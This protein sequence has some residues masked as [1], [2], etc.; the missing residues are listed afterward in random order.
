MHDLAIIIPA[1]KIDF[2]EKTLQ[3]ISSQTCKNFT[4]YVGDDNSG[5]DFVSIIDK[6][7]DIID[8]KY[9]KFTD[10]LGATNLVGQWS[11]CVD[12]T[13]G[14]KWLWLFS[15]DDVLEDRCVEMFYKTIAENPNHDIYHFNIN[16]IDEDNQVISKPT[17]YP[18]T[19]DSITFY[20]KKSSGVL[21]S[22]VVEYIFTR[23]IYEE[24]GGFQNFDL[25]WGSDIATWI[26]MSSNRGICTIPDA[27]VFW[28]QSSVNI[29]PTY[30]RNVVLRKLSAE[31]SYWVWIKSFFNDVN[32]NWHI[33]RMICKHLA[34]YSQSINNN[35]VSLFL[36]KAFKNTLINRFE[37]WIIYL[38]YPLLKLCKTI[39]MIVK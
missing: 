28:R 9:H 5:N 30:D 13:E 31:V 26:K 35:D 36:V 8:I 7:K 15:D 18:K 39:K 27:L 14:E 24:V 19:I 33:K 23:K 2:F 29:T 4:L 6:Y 37:L 25:A 1:Y 34:F 38:I 11:R 16:I 20:L 3:S 21:D 12:L 10:N 17:A 32:I 22:F